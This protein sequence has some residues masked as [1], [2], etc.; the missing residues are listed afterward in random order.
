[1]A[2][3]L[4]LASSVLL[5]GCVSQSAAGTCSIKSGKS[6][7]KSGKSVGRPKSAQEC[8]ELVQSKEPT[9]NGFTWYGQYGHC[10]AIFGATSIGPAKFKSEACIFSPLPSLPD[11]NADYV[12]GE[13]GKDACPAGFHGI[14]NRKTCEYASNILKLK[15]TGFAKDITKENSVCHVFGTYRPQRTRISKDH[16]DKDKYVCQKDGINAVWG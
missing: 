1:M 2:R 11:Q 3:I 16:D 15:W 10:I 6:M 9:A 13:V 7:G 12:L 5:F 8:L 14:W 4:I